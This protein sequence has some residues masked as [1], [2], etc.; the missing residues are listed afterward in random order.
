M[1]EDQLQVVGLDE[2]RSLKL[3]LYSSELD[4]MPML[5]QLGPWI[6]FGATGLIEIYQNI[7]FILITPYFSVV[8]DREFGLNLTMVDKPNPT[9]VTLM[10]DQEVGM[11]IPLYEPRVTFM[12]IEYRP[13]VLNGK[14]EALIKCAVLLIEQLSGRVEAPEENDYLIRAITWAQFNALPP[15]LMELARDS[16]AGYLVPGPQGPQGVPGVPG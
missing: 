10:L 1:T 13:D 16:I 15:E 2:I 11:K 3:D 8:L 12:E 5:L 4:E 7:K 14:L 9:V 6:D